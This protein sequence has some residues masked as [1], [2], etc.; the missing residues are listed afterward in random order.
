MVVE[1][2]KPLFRRAADVYVYVENCVSVENSTATE[3]ALYS[4]VAQKAIADP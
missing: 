4:E 1:V 3:S 2:K